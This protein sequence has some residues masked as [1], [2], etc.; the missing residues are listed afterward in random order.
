MPI[1]VKWLHTN[2]LSLN[3]IKTHIMI[4]GPRHRTVEYHITI[5]IE[6]TQIE[7]VQETKL[8][9]IILDSGLSWKK[10]LSY[11]SKKISK[12]IGILSRA[13][14]MLNKD[15]LLQLYYSFLYPFFT[16]CNIIWGNASDIHLNQIFK[17]QKRAVRISCNIRKRYTT[18]IDCFRL[19][20]LRIP[21]I[22]KFSV[23]IFMFRY[24]NGTL[25]SIFDNYFIENRALHR[26]PTRKAG[27]LR[28]PKLK[29]KI[30]TSF[31][32][33]T[34]AN[35]WNLYSPRLAQTN[36][37]GP[38]KKELITLLISNYL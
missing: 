4:F 19:R 21:D 13:R 3:L 20:I 8:L 5:F 9:G 10:H 30:A 23:I 16:Y 26:Y 25:P 38:F 11:L 29:S 2:R 22:Y 33:K 7:I 32:R 36:K 14:Q 28:P 1:L 34:G 12:S 35:L 18:T 24:K 31:I 6:G 37:I 27:N 17:L 15:I